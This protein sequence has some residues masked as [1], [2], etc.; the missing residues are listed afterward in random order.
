LTLPP[1]FPNTVGETFSCTLCANNELPIYNNATNITGVRITAEMQTPSQPDGVPLDLAAAE[2]VNADT[3]LEPGATLQRIVRFDLKEDGN[4][5]L[6]VTVTYT[7]TQM[8]G[9]GQAAGGQVRTFKKLYQFVAR[10]LLS[11]RTKVQLMPLASTNSQVRYALEAQLENL[12]ENAVIL[13]AV[14][15]VPRVGFISKSLNAWDLALDEN[16]VTNKPVLNP[17]DVMQV[18]FKVSQETASVDPSSRDASETRDGR[19]T[20]G[21]LSIQWRGPMGDLGSLSTGWLSGKRI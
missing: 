8:A 14:T 15:F 2:E 6:A 17:G 11:V 10:H 7:Q 9:E 3:S 16:D 21:Q 18:A 12:A 20:I 13:E 19:V 5:I 4:H 1:A